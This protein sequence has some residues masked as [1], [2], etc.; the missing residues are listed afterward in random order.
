MNSEEDSAISD[1]FPS[2]LIA[3]LWKDSRCT[4]LHS[5][6]HNAHC[7]CRFKSRKTSRFGRVKNKFEKQHWRRLPQIP[8]V[9][10]TLLRAC[11]TRLHNTTSKSYCMEL[12][13]IV[14]TAEE[15]PINWFAPRTGVR[16]LTL[17]GFVLGLAL[18]KMRR[19]MSHR[20]RLRNVLQIR[21]VH[22]DEE[23]TILIPMCN[24]IVR[25]TYGLDATD[26]GALYSSISLL[27]DL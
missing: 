8:T 10:W 17:E 6:V 1:H 2:F 19:F 11:V 9:P 21:R 20:G 3:L 16:W 18:S 13:K 12:F 24:V 25:V 5:W 27:I 7:P 22:C 23:T 4:K 14:N 26:D 15:T